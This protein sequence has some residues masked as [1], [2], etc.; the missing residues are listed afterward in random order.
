MFGKQNPWKGLSSLPIPQID[1]CLFFET[2]LEC[3]LFPEAFPF[4]LGWVML[5]LRHS[6]PLFFL[7]L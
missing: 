5:E 4:F 6:Q 1:S 3:H 2:L 7:L